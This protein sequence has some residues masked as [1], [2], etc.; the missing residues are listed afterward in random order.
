MIYIIDIYT[1][2]LSYY[3]LTE[4]WLRCNIFVWES[5]GKKVLDIDYN[6]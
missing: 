4:H 1:Y 2:I 5:I 3:L 6:S